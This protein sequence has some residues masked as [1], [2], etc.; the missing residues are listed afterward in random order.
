MRRL[1]PAA[2]GAAVLAVLQFAA[3]ARYPHL[4]AWHSASGIVHLIFLATVLLTGAAGLARGCHPPTK[5][6][7]STML[8][9][10]EGRAD[11]RPPQAPATVADVM[12][13]AAETVAEGDHVTPAA[14][15]DWASGSP[16]AP[17]FGPR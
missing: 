17:R 14:V 7:T 8:S 11:S 12:R 15:R 1:W 2:A 4:F 9:E 16:P 3:L 13:L 6:E 5:K 10:P